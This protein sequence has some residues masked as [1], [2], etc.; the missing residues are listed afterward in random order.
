MHNAVKQLLAD[1]QSSPDGPKIAA[2]FDFD[3]T[4]IAGYSATTFIR[5]QLKR[6]D[7][8]PRQFLE[9]MRA[10]SNFGLGN[11]GFSGMMAINAQFMRG[12]EEETY[13]E[14]GEA[15]YRKQIARLIYPE[16]R[17]LVEAHLAKGHTVAI[18]S[19]ATPYQVEPAAAD[20]GIDHVLCTHLEVEDGK[21]TGGIVSPTCFGSGKVNAAETLARHYRADL[22]KSF[23]YS[24]S[25]DDLLLLERVGL[26]RAL[27]PS[28]RLEKIARAR[29]WPIAKLG[30]RGRPSLNQFIR[31]IAATGSLVTSFMAGLPVYALT[32][33]RRDSQNFSFSLFA[34][35]ASALIGMD[36]QVRGEE[37]LWSHRPAVFVFN[38]QSKAD[39]IIAARLL[40]RDIAGI[41]KQEIKKETPLL[42]KVME[43]G[44]VV[45]IDRADGKSAI[46]AIAPLVNAMRN[47]GKSVVLAPEG[48]RSATDKLAPFKKGAFHL[49][50]QAGVPMVPIVI[51][52]STDVAPK[53]DFVFRPATVEIEVL[54]PVDTSSWAAESLDT[55]VREVRNMFARALGQAQE[56]TPKP[57]SKT[58][59]KVVPKKV[60]AKTKTKTKAKGKAKTKAKTQTTVKKQ[61]A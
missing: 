24:D 54:P 6:G 30:S 5:E 3:G 18:I 46:N 51:H 15:L 60:S 1:I 17:A 35:T 23:F 52:N 25:Q 8:K 16:S 42:G 37:H 33:S 41:G 2:I 21:F 36:L 59:A 26:P 28:T 58:A 13:H 19:S 32:G 12:I 10:M 40:R 27:N 43:L 20:L 61:N 4:I 14:V 55:H 48:T 34:D 57:R 44:G 9:L 49:A 31:S 50:M 22:D 53:G 47:E 7:L 29:Q 56:N 45:F 38:H 39:V 11:L